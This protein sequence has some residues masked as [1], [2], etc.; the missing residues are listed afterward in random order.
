MQLPAHF[1]HVV[2][3]G[4]IEQHCEFLTAVAC[5]EI[6]GPTRRHRQHVRDLRETCIA[7]LVAAAVVE[8][9][10]VIEVDEEQRKRHAL[11]Q[12]LLPQPLHVV[13]EHAP[14]VDAGQAVAVRGFAQHLL[15]EIV[16]AHA[17]LEREVD[18]ATD[19]AGEADDEHVEHA[20]RAAYAGKCAT[21]GVRQDDEQRGTHC[22]CVQHAEQEIRGQDDERH[23]RAQR[24]AARM[25]EDVHHDERQRVHGRDDLRGEAEPLAVQRRVGN[26]Q[27]RE[28]A[29]HDEA[30][31]QHVDEQLVLRPEDRIAHV[32]ERTAGEHHDQHVAHREPHGVAHARA[33]VLGVPVSEFR[34]QRLLE[35]QA[36]HD[37]RDEIAE[38]GGEGPGHEAVRALWQG[39]LSFRST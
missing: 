25:H 24:V 9:L 20:L 37:A 3:A 32:A 15:R 22:L 4:V 38:A 34:L 29:R 11:A 31:A 2:A 28:A 18:R 8:G 13:V 27:H 5:R 30:E 1:F 36:R 14:V 10:E 21:N 35:R 12:G 17:A 16:A 19:R 33:R 7:G 6:E 39:R 23:P 26:E